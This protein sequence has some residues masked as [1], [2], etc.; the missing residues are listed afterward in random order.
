MKSIGA[1]S[2]VSVLALLGGCMVV[3]V[4]PDYY[5]GPRGYAPGYYGAPAYYGPSI[6]FG[7]YGGRGGYGHG[8]G[9]GKRNH[10][11]SPKQSRTR[12][13]VMRVLL[14]DRPQMRSL[15]P[16]AYTAGVSN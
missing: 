3:P 8:H 5:A 2:I 15:L 10:L 12:G 9:R 6:G 11:S 1:M 16:G 13:D 7:I 4:N 14:K